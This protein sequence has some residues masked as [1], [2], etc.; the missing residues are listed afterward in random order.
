[1]TPSSPSSCPHEMYLSEKRSG[2]GVSE[3]GRDEGEGGGGGDGFTTRCG[4]VSPLSLQVFSSVECGAHFSP[5]PVTW[6]S[7]SFF[8]SS[9]GF[10]P[11]NSSP[12]GVVA[13]GYP[14][15]PSS[16]DTF[17]SSSLPPSGPNSAAQGMGVDTTTTTSQR[18]E[19]TLSSGT[20]LRPPP[21]PSPCTFPERESNASCFPSSPKEAEH[22][23]RIALKPLQANVLEK[24]QQN[25]PWWRST[26]TSEEPT[27]TS[28]EEEEEEGRRGGREGTF[29]PFHPSSPPTTTTASSSCCPSSSSLPCPGGGNNMSPEEKAKPL[30]HSRVQRRGASTSSVPS[31][32][33]LSSRERR[34]L[35]SSPT[36]VEHE[37][38]PQ[39]WKE[40]VKLRSGIALNTSP[41]NEPRSTTSY[42]LVASGGGG[43][44]ALHVSKEDPSFSTTTSTTREEER[45][46]STRTISP[47][48]LPFSSFS[49][50]SYTP[51]G[52]EEEVRSSSRPCHHGSIGSLSSSSFHAM[53]SFL[54]PCSPLRNDF[55][56][57]P[58]HFV[59]SPASQLQRQTSAEIPSPV[60]N[61]VDAIPLRSTSV[62]SSSCTSCCIRSPPPSR[63][64]PRSLDSVALPPTMLW[65]REGSFC[66]STREE[67]E[68]RQ[69]EKDETRTRDVGTHRRRK[70]RRMMQRR[71]ESQ[72][73]G[74]PVPHDHHDEEEEEEDEE[75]SNAG[76]RSRP[77]T[78]TASPPLPKPPSLFF[79]SSTP[80]T[81]EK[82]V[83]NGGA[84]W[85]DGPVPDPSSTDVTERRGGG[86]GEVSNVNHHH[87][88]HHPSSSPV[89]ISP[90]LPGRGGGEE[91]Q[92]GKQPRP[93]PRGMAWPSSPFSSVIPCKKETTTCEGTSSRTAA[94]YALETTR[95]SRDA[96]GI[97]GGS[98]VLTTTTTTVD[99]AA[100]TLLSVPYKDSPSPQTQAPPSWRREMDDM[101]REE[102]KR[103]ERAVVSSLSSGVVVGAAHGAFTHSH[104]GPS[105]LTTTTPV[106]SPLSRS[107]YPLRRPFS[108]SPPREAHDNDRFTRRSQSVEPHRSPSPS[109]SG[110]L[111]PCSSSPL[112]FDSWG[113]VP[114]GG[115]DA[116]AQTMSTTKDGNRVPSQRDGPTTTTTL[117]WRRTPDVAPP[118][119]TTWGAISGGEVQ[120]A[121]SRGNGEGGA[122][123]LPAS[124]STAAAAAAA[125]SSPRGG[126]G[127]SPSFSSSPPP[128][129]PLPPLSGS[130]ADAPQPREEEEEEEE[131]EKWRTTRSTTTTD[132]VPDVASVVPSSYERTS[133]SSCSFRHG[134]SGVDHEDME[135][136]SFAME[137]R[138]EGEDAAGGER[139][140]GDE[141]PMPSFPSTRRTQPFAGTGFLPPPSPT[142][143]SFSS[144]TCAVRSPMDD[145]P[146]QPC[147]FSL[148]S[149]GEQKERLDVNPP[150]PTVDT[151]EDA[152]RQRG[153]KWNE[154]EMRG[155]TTY[156]PEEEVAAGE[157]RVA[158]D[159]NAHQNG[160]E[161]EDAD[162][163]RSSAPSSLFS[164][165][166]ATDLPPERESLLGEIEIGRETV[167]V[168]PPSS[169]TH[170]SR[171]TFSH[172]P[173]AMTE[174]EIDEVYYLQHEARYVECADGDLLL[175]LEAKSQRQRLIEDSQCSLDMLR[176]K[177]SSASLT[178]PLEGSPGGRLEG[179]LLEERDTHVVPL[180]PQRSGGGAPALPLCASVH[181][182]FPSSSSSALFPM[183]LSSSSFPSSSPGVTGV[184]ASSLAPFSFPFMSG[185]EE[186]GKED[187]RRGLPASQMPT[188]EARE[189]ALLLES[190][191]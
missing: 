113:L 19:G 156:R 146:R 69:V 108:P 164:L 16:Y 25:T 151:R 1:M 132:I 140:E 149:E 89:P 82:A 78:E 8:S 186:V 185:R 63:L 126:G 92:R 80:F 52:D 45:N 60:V 61:P 117:P 173:E 171:R 65:S 184:P 88:H 74:S 22:S 139:H 168:L 84:L 42:G 70:T 83:R 142:T 94:M 51:V 34:S 110:M 41:F 33:M 17:S 31:S 95:R 188:K 56:V 158:H 72:L 55:P 99:S 100:R 29:S 18:S 169:S 91:G 166:R 85:W 123:S 160:M 176:W 81:G 155:G 189:L 93:P 154:E 112:S 7:P 172:F 141:S 54:S 127:A 106:V 12:R 3:M 191:F 177:R 98:D 174:P 11:S 30:W 162:E 187:L 152:K 107:F 9:F 86:G 59:T 145:A 13:S 103:T 125:G 66:T 161:L 43:G 90:P 2:D 14:A 129:P 157:A 119:C 130:S 136:S 57:S 122:P 104:A 97:G 120:V 101:R 24:T 131:G 179:S 58:F 79:S 23:F 135:R 68:E 114:M 111:S 180:L 105:P 40:R 124:F 148:G 147:R 44:G 38:L 182:H 49:L 67:G 178:L 32:L 134:H 183:P 150:V 128:R 21:L 143:T 175:Q 170:P 5:C 71:I 159:S 165:P 116:V 115:G 121:T 26:S 138:E 15:S 75:F 190:G 76:A 20:P 4:E 137:E 37:N 73:D 27:R 46:P 87:H 102:E 10:S 109:P 36:C 118:P 47:L 48:P 144:P 50:A 153:W 39:K 62:M 28:T 133:P 77:R 64:P 167:N 53:T 35:A 181:H 96:I 6:E 163:N